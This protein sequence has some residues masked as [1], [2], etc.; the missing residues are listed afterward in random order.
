MFL[1]NLL[2]LI[3]R[4][5]VYSLSYNMFGI[6][7]FF[8]LVLF[9][10]DDILFHNLLYNLY[11]VLSFLYVWN[12]NNILYRNLIITS[13]LNTSSSRIIKYYDLFLL[14]IHNYI[15]VCQK[16]LKTQCYS[17]ENLTNSLFRITKIYS[18]MLMTLTILLL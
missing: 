18:I 10:I 12:D 16:L 9:W 2:A 6:D 17:N 5:N 15:F 11:I 13:E 4:I 14:Y 7:F 3:N 1:L 8:E